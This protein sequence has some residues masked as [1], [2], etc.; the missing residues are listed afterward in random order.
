MMSPRD[1]SLKRTPVTR[2]A[3]VVKYDNS[4]SSS[5]AVSPSNRHMVLV[6]SVHV[7]ELPQTYCTTAQYCSVATSF[8][9]LE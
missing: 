3:P 2:A 5:F 9:Q 8:E 7:I 6:S 1:D 4:C